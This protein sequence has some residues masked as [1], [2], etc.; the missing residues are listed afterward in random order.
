MLVISFT[1]L[2]FNFLDNTLL[3]LELL[4]FIFLGLEA[5]EGARALSSS[6]GWEIRPVL[7]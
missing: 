1:M 3:M 6:L 5:I 2:S 4:D 7:G